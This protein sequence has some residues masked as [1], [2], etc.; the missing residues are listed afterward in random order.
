MD[1]YTEK[2]QNIFKGREEETAKFTHD[3]VTGKY[4]ITLIAGDSG[5]GK[6]SLVHAGLKPI[7]TDKYFCDVV[8]IDTLNKSLSDTIKENIIETLRTGLINDHWAILPFIRGRSTIEYSLLLGIPVVAST[9]IV[10]EEVDS[11][12]I[13]C[14]Y[15]YDDFQ[16]TCSTI[17]QIRDHIRS[18]REYRA[19]DS[20]GWTCPHWAPL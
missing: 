10:E 9:H 12:D 3:I 1:H 15:K 5:S 20:I 8:I 11:G 6:S 16:K 7:L 4:P 18:E 17:S 19:I 2:D 13:I 14:L